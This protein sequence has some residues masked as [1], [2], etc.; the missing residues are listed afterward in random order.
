VPPLSSDASRVSPGLTAAVLRLL[1]PNQWTKNAFVLVGVM[2]AHA[3]DEPD[4]VWAALVAFA[5]FCAAASAVYVVN[6]WF[7]RER[8]RLHPRKR[9]RPIA[10]GRVGGA[11]AIVLAT[12]MF[13]LAIGLA[14]APPIAGLPDADGGTRLVLILVLYA[15]MNL[16]YSLGLK[17]VPILDCSLIA[18]GFMLRILA[19]TWAIGI[20]PSR[21]LL[22]CGLSVTLF[23]A[24]AKRRAELAALGDDAGGHR[25]VLD[26]YSL[27]LLDQFLAITAT[28]VLVTYSVY[29]VSA[30]T[31]QI[32]GTDQ[33]LWTLPFVAYGLF[34]YL[35]IV[36]Q[37]G[38]GG[39]PTRDLFGD[40]HL[41]V[42]GIAWF[43]STVWVLRSTA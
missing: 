5:A 8:D 36:F 15:L 29:T 23:L 14:Y 33:L 28:A 40:P 31:V 13:A 42:S 37:R 41:V 1:R 38:A 30:E 20:P 7:D 18:L 10:S 26:R 4:R 22:V 19:G 35:Y 25:A 17:H 27:P 2:F 12:S 32:H 34:R 16:G 39:D 9:H 43:V 21:W 3:W 24:F 6:D 11:L